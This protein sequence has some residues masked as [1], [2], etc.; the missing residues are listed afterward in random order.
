MIQY[1][2]L[3]L[4]WCIFYVS[5][6][7]CVSNLAALRE[8]CIL[9]D[10]DFLK[11]VYAPHFETQSALLLCDRY[12]NLWHADFSGRSFFEL[13][14]YIY[15]VWNPPRSELKLVFL[16]FLNGAKVTCSWIDPS[17]DFLRMGNFFASG[18]HGRWILAVFQKKGCRSTSPKRCIYER[19]VLQ[20]WYTSHS[21][22][23]F[24]PFAV[25][26]S[27]Q[28]PMG[29]VFH[30]PRISPSVPFWVGLPDWRVE[31]AHRHRSDGGVGCAS[32]LPW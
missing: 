12:A 19:W 8:D 31:M 14:R 28:N 32:Q 20:G 2:A 16:C 6:N 29:H 18:Y 27:L 13:I 30:L 26:L 9:S 25:V 22:V 15:M 11:D 3:L 7:M 4:R 10:L 5:Q 21:T 23:E 17:V 1:I 24:L